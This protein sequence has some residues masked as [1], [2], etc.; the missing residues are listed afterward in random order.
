MHHEIINQK[1]KK[2]KQ[3][4]LLKLAFRPVVH[5]KMPVYPQPP[6]LLKIPLFS[7]LTRTAM[8]ESM[9]RC[10]VDFPQGRKDLSLGWFLFADSCLVSHR[11]L[12]S[13]PPN[14]FHDTV[15]VISSFTPAI[16]IVADELDSTG[17]IVKQVPQLLL[18]FL[19][20]SS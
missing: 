4:V 6:W 19:S 12:Q 16:P 1:K 13:A 3:L 20:S 18:L 14:N 5:K 8:W 15:F 2:I 17:T 9:K 7:P 11:T 10:I